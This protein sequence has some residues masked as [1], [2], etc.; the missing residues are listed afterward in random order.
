[1]RNAAGLSSVPAH[2]AVVTLLA[3]SLLAAVLA[4]SPVDAQGESTIE[5][6][7]V[8]AVVE[9][10]DGHEHRASVPPLRAPGRSLGLDGAQGQRSGALVG[11][12]RDGSMTTTYETST[13]ASV[14]AVIDAAVAEWDRSLA[15]SPTAPVEISVRWTDLGV[16]LLGQAGTEGEYRNADRFPTDRW[17]PAALANQLANFDVNGPDTPEVLVELNSGLGDDWYIGT[18]G[19][20]GVG[21]IDLYSVVL[22]EIAHGLGFLGSALRSRDGSL[23]IDQE[24]P[25]IYDDFLETAD[26]QTVIDLPMEDALDALTSDSLRV[27]IG[28][29]RLMPVHS[30]SRFVNGSSYSHFDE[31]IGEDEPGAMMTPA[32]K[33]G[34]IQRD[35]DAAVLGVLSQVGW[36][37]AAPLLEP[38]LADINVKSGSVEVT[39]TEDWNEVGAFSERYEL[40][41]TP[42]ASSGP[43]P[44]PVTRTVDGAR[45]SSLSLRGL[46]NGTSYQLSITGERPDTPSSQ[47]IGTTLLLPANPNLV[48]ELSARADSNGIV[49]LWAPPIDSGEAVTSYEVNYRGATDRAWK[50]A[51]VVD[52]AWSTNLAPGRYWFRVRGQNRVGGGLWTETSLLGLAPGPVRP[53]PLDGQLSRL[54]AAY[55]GRTPDAEGMDYWR[56]VRSQSVSI[57]S[58]STEFAASAE[59][60]A[61]YGSLTDEEFVDQI[62]RNVLGRLPDADGYRYWLGLLQAGTSRGTVVLWISESQEFVT[63]TGTMPPQSSLAGSVER[64]HI[65]LLRRAPAPAELDRLVDRRRGSSLRTVAFELSQSDEFQAVWAD[66]VGDDLISVIA[67]SAGIDAAEALTFSTRLQA[68]ESLA[69]LL[70]EITEQPGFILS[71]G[72]AP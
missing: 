44:E 50:A 36:T 66:H 32:L 20:P 63:S 71:T 35:I 25:S 13:P 53:M 72:T 11:N 18:D 46:Q 19:A 61:T 1:M 30:P 38:T 40:E 62:Y 68:G 28:F 2:G 3:L 12:R 9:T 59:F 17:Y 31:S 33:N 8:E 29:G 69:T 4:A 15:L 47:S 16:R 23:S 51:T 60:A 34:E 37:I 21:Q 65:G 42:L 57:E 67:E 56:R 43:I 14:R 26:G 7:S 39:W 10:T 24:S 5:R 48:T 52:T 49:V 41:V 64:L 22:H 55:F 45:S 6:R 54:Y 27:D 58:V 70:V